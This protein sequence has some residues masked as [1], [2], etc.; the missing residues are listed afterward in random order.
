MAALGTSFVDYTTWV[1]ITTLL[2]CGGAI[3]LNLCI[4]SSLAQMNGGLAPFIC[5]PSH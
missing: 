4:F 2:K 1:V 3:G 5:L